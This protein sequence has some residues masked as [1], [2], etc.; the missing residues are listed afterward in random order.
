MRLYGLS[1]AILVAILALLFAIL[2]KISPKQLPNTPQ[3]CF[4][5]HPNEPQTPK[6][7][8]KVMEGCLFLHF[9]HFPDIH[10][11]V[12]QKCSQNQPES[13]KLRPTWL[14][15]LHHGAPRAPT[16][17][18][19][20]PSCAH[21]LHQQCQHTPQQRARDPKKRSPYPARPPKCPQD[22]QKYCIFQASSMDFV[23]SEPSEI[24]IEGPAAEASAF[25]FDSRASE[26][27]CF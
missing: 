14:P 20:R 26:K 7:T 13:S 19:L 24:V 4:P 1:L 5:E 15:W 12:I 8:Q 25:R 21:F 16:W 23:H 11:K 22:N 6:N 3:D 9:D 18:I 27:R 2:T 17:S 10:S